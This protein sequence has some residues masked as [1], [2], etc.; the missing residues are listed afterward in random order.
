MSGPTAL[1]VE[2]A[3]TVA[4]RIP[5]QYRRGEARFLYRLARRKGQIVEIGCYMGRTTA[6]LVQAARMWG[7]TVTTVDPFVPLPNGV[8]QATPDKWRA[9]LER[10]GLRPP[11]LL[12]VPSH[13]AA[14]QWA[15]EIAFLFVDGDHSYT[16][17]QH[18]LADW[19]P[20]VQVG[21]VI[22]LHDM[23]FPSITGVARAV[24]EWWCAERD[25]AAR[26]DSGAAWRCLGMRDYTIAFRRER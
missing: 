19:A 7:A 5:G 18:D 24:T 22:A 2:R 21:G 17:V 3:V 4:W 6:L 25:D 20:R 9:H 10:V 23:W 12:A 13:E 14:R 26:G 15:G 1:E 16:G 11:R 8:E